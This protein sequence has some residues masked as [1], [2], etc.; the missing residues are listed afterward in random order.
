MNF[1]TPDAHAQSERSK[2]DRLIEQKRDFNKNNRSSTVFKI[3]LFNG[4]EKEALE[5]RE[6]F[7]EEFPDYKTILLYRAPE[8]KTQVG[9]FKTRLEADK[10]LL[11]IRKE[12]PGAIVL[13]DRI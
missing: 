7:E 9:M 6:K 2:I 5:I 12:F 10:V 8:W 11:K 1:N 13:E 4:N 3:Q